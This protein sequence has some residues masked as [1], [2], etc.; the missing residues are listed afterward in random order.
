MNFDEDGEDSSCPRIVG[1]DG[2]FLRNGHLACRPEHWARKRDGVDDSSLENGPALCI[3][4]HK[5]MGT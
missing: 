5:F 1:E 4:T 3:R 2:R